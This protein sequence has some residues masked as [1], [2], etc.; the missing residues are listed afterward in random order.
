[1]D[2]S[3]P[4]SFYQELSLATTGYIMKK[5][6]IPNVDSGQATILKHLEENGVPNHL[7]TEYS[8]ILNRC[9]LAKFAGRYGN[10]EE[11]YN[12]A[13]KLIEEV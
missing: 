9:E 10:M 2:K 12:I 7:I 13:L 4:A 8:Q 11:E 1:M 3:D 6:H 5:Y